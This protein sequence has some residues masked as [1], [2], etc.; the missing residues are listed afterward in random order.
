MRSGWAVSGFLLWAGAVSALELDLASNARETTS[1][2]SVI[3]SYFVPLAPFADGVLPGRT[4]EGEVRRTSF[5]IGSPGLTPLQVLQPLRAQ[6]EA[7][8]YDIVLDCA[9]ADCG[10][11]DFRFAIETLQPPAM[12]V[13][14]RR[15]HFVSAIQGRTEAPERAVTLLA[16]ASDTAAH[17]QVIEAGALGD[18]P[19]QF[20]RQGTLV[21]QTPIPE[22]VA[23]PTEPTDFATTLMRDGVA[24]LDDLAFASGSSNLTDGPFDTLQ[25][26]AR[27]MGEDPE[28]RIAVV[29]HT[30]N[31]GSLAA[32]IALSRA[33][34][35]S[36][37][38]RLLQAYEIAGSRIE[39]EGVGYLSPVAS[40]NTPEN[41]GR[42]RRVE[43]VVLKG[44]R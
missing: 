36:V 27:L 21:G 3:D 29:G 24:V 37:R 20:T 35:R 42:N 39:A 26:V 40:N 33:R 16:S 13:N 12:Y 15:F 43:V 18:T 38:T 25:T 34:A 23:P 4:L 41:R 28:L 31:V 11:F 19:D 9:D 1:Q 30:D 10:G 6:L 7:A 17:L 5:R 22:E 44:N 14:L 8:G 32:N 2:N